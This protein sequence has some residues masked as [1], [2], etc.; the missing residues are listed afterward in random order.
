MLEQNQSC[1]V[2]LSFQILIRE[3]LTLTHRWNTDSPISI[4]QKI[5]LFHKEIEY[6]S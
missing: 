6:D 2:T 3:V 5:F 4:L 1:P